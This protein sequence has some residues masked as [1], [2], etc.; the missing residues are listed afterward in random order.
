MSDNTEL[1]VG[2]GGVKATS[3]EVAFAGDTTQLQA[4]ALMGASGTEGSYTTALIGGDA[5]NGIDVDVTRS[6]L[7]TGAST[8]A[9]QDTGNTSLGAINTDTTAIA[10]SASVMDDWDESDRAKVNLIVGQ[11]GVQGA[12]GAVSATTQRVVLATDVA[13]PAGT[14]AIGKLAANSGVD[15][16]DVDVTSIAAGDNNIGNV[17]IVTVPADP[18]GANG[19]AASATGSIS[20]KLRFIA[21]TGI[22]VTGTVTVG[23]HAVTNAGTFATQVDGA[24]LTA[25]QLMDD[26]IIVDDAAFTPATT[27]VTMVGFQADEASTDSVDEGDAGAAR[28]TLDRKLIVSPQPHSAGGLN[29]FRTLD[30]DETEEDIKTSA[31]CVYGMWVTNTDTATAFIKFYNATAANVTVG[32]TTPVITIGIPGNTTDDVSGN[33]GPGGM[34]IFFDTAICIAAV[35]T[36]ADNGSTGPA[37]NSVIVN[38]FY[39]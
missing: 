23:A 8:A 10:A 3:L 11:A 15:I 20:A 14:N 22:P 19:D 39:K 13:L 29:I 6:A 25:L 28:M 2:S 21:G 38:V 16:G 35:T 7:P 18:F 26:P 37:A 30:A 1:N 36:A 9:R 34:G 17:D 5:A 12:S 31:G 33:F 27:K 24:A 32:S 4:V